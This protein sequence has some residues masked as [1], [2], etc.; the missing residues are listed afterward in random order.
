[1]TSNDS[2]PRL[3]PTGVCWCG[4]GADATLGKFFA[5]GHDKTA[6]AALLAVE[7]DASV[8]RLLVAH[9]YGPDRPVTAA[10]VEAGAWEKCPGC[11]YV[12]APASLRKHRKNTGH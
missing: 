3:I 9:G 6:E 12:G 10:A 4:C 2:S 5:Q 11:T 8:A 7:Y 1:M